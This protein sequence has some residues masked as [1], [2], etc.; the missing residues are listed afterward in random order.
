MPEPDAIVWVADYDL[1]VR[2][3]LEGLIRSA[4]LSFL[5]LL[6]HEPVPPEVPPQARPPDFPDTAVVSGKM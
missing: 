1:S 4:G 6:G 5:W 3:A 2:E